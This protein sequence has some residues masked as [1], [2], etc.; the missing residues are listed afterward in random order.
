MKN[1]SIITPGTETGIL[2][3]A[4]ANEKL[5]TILNALK[6]RFDVV[7]FISGGVESNMTLP[8]VSDM[9]DKTLLVL[10]SDQL[11]KPYLKF[12]KLLKPQLNEDKMMVVV[13]GIKDYKIGC[14]KTLIKR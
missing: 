5:Q 3:E 13:N 14:I 7:V 8:I 1:I 4:L 2:Q 6:E 10:R 9:V 12:Y 11:A